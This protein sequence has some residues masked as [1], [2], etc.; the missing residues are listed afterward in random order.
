MVLQ[1]LNDVS[2]AMLEFL[3][4]FGRARSSTSQR[5]IFC[6]GYN[7]TGT[8]SVAKVLGDY[9]F[10]LPHQQ[11]QERMTTLATWR[12][13]YRPLKKLILSYDAFH[14]LPFSQG[15]TYVACDALFPDSRFILTVRE[16]NDWFD[17]LIRFDMKRYGWRSLDDANEA[18]F[19][20]KKHYLQKNYC[21]EGVAMMLR[22]AVGQATKVD[23]SLLYD[24]DHYIHRYSQRNEA[25]QR[26]FANRPEQLLVIDLGQE[27]DTQR[28]RDFLGLR[29]APVF[30][31]PRLNTTREA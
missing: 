12:N 21:Y 23:W 9:G 27:T 30:P 28:I 7:K 24:R 4:N 16:P 2:V 18:F 31:M 6:I 13:D 19:L 29:K 25:I 22:T 11:F 26:Y 10:R 1:Y 17:S 8:T 5:K 3:Q 14:D 20:D 15:E